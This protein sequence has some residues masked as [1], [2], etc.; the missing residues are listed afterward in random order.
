[1]DEIQKKMKV[2]VVSAAEEILGYQSKYNPREWFD[3]KCQEATEVKNKKYVEFI[4]TAIRKRQEAYKEARRIVS[5]IC[6]K[7]KWKFLNNQL[8]QMEE[9]F[10]SNNTK[11]VYKQEKCLKEGYKPRTALVRKNKREI[12]SERNDIL[13]VWKEY[14]QQLLKPNQN[15]DPDNSNIHRNRPVGEERDI[16]P[17]TVEE[18]E[19]VM[20]STRPNKALGA[21]G[22]PITLLRAGEEYLLTL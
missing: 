14:F 22:I 4:E 1:M 5:K 2:S 21:D 8:L 10:K 11:Q 20:E 19:E 7:K 16:E 13:N 3:R 15:I 12:I 6:R 9:D 17:P 18:V